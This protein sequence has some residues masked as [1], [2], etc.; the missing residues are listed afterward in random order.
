MFVR[1]LFV[2]AFS[3]HGVAHLVGFLAAW[4]LHTSPDVPYTTTVFAGHI[5]IGA[6][7]SRAGQQAHEA[8]GAR[9]NG[10]A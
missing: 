9:R 6:A 7:G 8:D 5:D 2:L 4:Q 1:A 10:L 3:A